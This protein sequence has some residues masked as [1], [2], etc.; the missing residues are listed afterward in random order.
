[1]KYGAAW[2]AAVAELPP[3]LQGA[4]VPYA[5][6][7]KRTRGAVPWSD[8]GPR[9]AHDCLRADAAL[10]PGAGAASGCCGWLCACLPT[11]ADVHPPDLVACARL[12][13]EALRKLCKRVDKRNRGT[14]DQGRAG[15]WLAL[16]R[17]LH[18]FAFLGG[19]AV[20]RIELE[21]A[22]SAPGGPGHDCP[23]CFEPCGTR[24]RPALVTACGHV[25]CEAC[26]E[27]VTGAGTVYGTFENRFA[28]ACDQW[29]R[30]CVCPLCRDPRAFRGLT[31]EGHRVAVR[32]VAAC[33]AGACGGGSVSH[34]S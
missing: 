1:M 5:A 10:R 2:K 11:R 23:V 9:L 4:C 15:R 30:R 26:A 31:E 22:A 27:R 32:N 18:A 12:N 8:V 20:A 19:A 29:P 17:T 14:P 33:A 25:L 34:G 28:F 24:A 16:C 13:S 21:R 3:D 7:K 6:W